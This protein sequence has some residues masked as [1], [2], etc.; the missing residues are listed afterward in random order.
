MELPDEPGYSDE[1]IKGLLCGRRIDYSE[2]RTLNDM[3]L[4]LLGW[5]YDVNFVPTLKRIKQRRF[6]EILVDFLPKTE[7]IKRVKDKI[8]EVVDFRISQETTNKEK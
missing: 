3:K 2:L 4:C 6:L 7:D 5:V 8:F 1:V